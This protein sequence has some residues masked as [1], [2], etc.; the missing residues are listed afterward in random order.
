MSKLNMAEIEWLVSFLAVQD[1]VMQCSFRNPRSRKSSTLHQCLWLLLW[2]K[3]NNTL[4]LSPLGI[5]TGEVTCCCWPL[6]FTD[7]HMPREDSF[8]GCCLYGSF[9]RRNAACITTEKLFWSV[10]DYIKFYWLIEMC[11]LP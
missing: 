2:G 3:K 8:F 11:M 9:W 6:L 1:T 10:N 4:L 5:D 7:Y